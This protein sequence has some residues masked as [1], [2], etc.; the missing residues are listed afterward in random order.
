MSVLR[1]TLVVGSSQEEHCWTLAVAVQ[2]LSFRYYRGCFRFLVAAFVADDGHHCRRHR[3]GFDGCWKVLA[4]SV[5]EEI[6]A[7]KSRVRV[8]GL[9]EADVSIWL[10][11]RV[12]PWQ[13]GVGLEPSDRPWRSFC[14]RP[15]MHLC[16]DQGIRFWAIAALTRLNWQKRPCI[17]L[18]PVRGGWRPLVH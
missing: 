5:A 9:V 1:L 17:S 11:P 10:A 14:D 6:P 13:V 3:G 7:M 12:A 15:A 4:A 16:N 18:R 2:D 8:E